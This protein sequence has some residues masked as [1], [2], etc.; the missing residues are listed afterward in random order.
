MEALLSPTAHMSARLRPVLGLD[1]SDPKNPQFHTLRISVKNE[2]TV[3]PRE[4]RVDVRVPAD[5]VLPNVLDNMAGPV[6]DGYKS[7]SRDQGWFGSPLLKD[8]SQVLW[9]L[10]F[11]IPPGTSPADPRLQMKLGIIVNAE[12]M[13]PY[14]LEI[15]LAEA[16]NYMDV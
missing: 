3:V 13:Q 1:R 6:R 5:F 2:S 9:R 16:L 11:S 7:A 4:I 15:P 8:D 10:M 12:G 14:R